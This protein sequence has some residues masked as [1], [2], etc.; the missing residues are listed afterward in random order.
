VLYPPHAVPPHASIPAA[1]A[2]LVQRNGHA[3]VRSNSTETRAGG[4]VLYFTVVS[5]ADRS[6]S[7]VKLCE[8]GH[9]RVTGTSVVSHGEP[10]C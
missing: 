9:G 3:R 4:F 8:D 6:A 5:S 10:S 7:V 1:R 2:Y